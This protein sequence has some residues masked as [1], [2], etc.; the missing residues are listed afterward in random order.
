MLVRQAI[1]RRFSY[2]T[3]SILEPS[4]NCSNAPK[5]ALAVYFALFSFQTNYFNF[6]LPVATCRYEDLNSYTPSECRPQS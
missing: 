3:L 2:S 5:I 6:A 1:D 4:L